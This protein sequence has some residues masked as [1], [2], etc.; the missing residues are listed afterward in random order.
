MSLILPALAAGLIGAAPPP[1]V[2]PKPAIIRTAPDLGVLP[3]FPVIRRVGPVLKDISFVA[4]ALSF[5]QNFTIPA[6]AKAG[7]LVVV[8][9]F[10]QEWLATSF[11]DGW[12]IYTGAHAPGLL[13]TGSGNYRCFV[14]SRVLA[15]DSEAGTSVV[16]GQTYNEGPGKIVLVFRKLGGSW[17]PPSNYSRAATQGNPSA[18]TVGGTAFPSVVIAHFCSSTPG[19][20]GVTFSPTETG[21]IGSGTQHEVRYLIQNT[22]AATVTVDMGDAGDANLMSAYRI[23]VT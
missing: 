22:A 2:F 6:T 19:V 8:S 18:L 20:T 23:A 16:G 4:S 10:D 13:V 17:N 9:D 5:S 1:L 7:D 12:E 15:S 21:F 3:G 11:P 14:Y